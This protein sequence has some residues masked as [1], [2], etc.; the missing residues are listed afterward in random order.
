MNNFKNKFIEQ[1]QL[2]EEYAK[3]KLSFIFNYRIISYNIKK[4]LK[5]IKDEALKEPFYYIISKERYALEKD[6]IDFLENKEES[7]FPAVGPYGIGKS[8]TASIIQ[9][10][11]ALKGIKSLYINLKYY[12]LII[13]FINKLETLM[14]ECFYL[15]LSEE[16]YLSYQKLFENKNYNDIW[17][18][19]KDIYENI[20]DY[21]NVLFIVDQ[22]KKSYDSH[23][24]I[25]QFEKV[26]IFLLSSINDKH[27][28]S[29]IE[30][31]F[32]K[33]NPK[34]KYHY[35]RQLIENNIELFK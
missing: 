34:L 15:C 17:L 10:N 12:S 27:I 25:F 13:P 24:N 5:S 4:Y 26:H 31:F 32:K 11:L 20:T 28:K 22:Y 2:L 16:N 1:K 18:Y 9:K 8:M 33:E 30:K 35:L 29:N 19:L 6:I 23:D 21:S 7:I 14:D 3:K